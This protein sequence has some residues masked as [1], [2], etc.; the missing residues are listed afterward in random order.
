[1]FLKYIS[2]S[3]F[4]YTHL[5]HTHRP[6]DGQRRV[7]AGFHQITEDAPPEKQPHQKR[8]DF[9]GGSENNAQQNEH[10]GFGIICTLPKFNSK[11][12]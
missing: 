9:G 5:H 1:M 11:S 3:I 4:H 8:G 12:P 10:P 2:H 7:G 6:K